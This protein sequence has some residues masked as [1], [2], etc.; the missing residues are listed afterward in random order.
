[1]QLDNNEDVGGLEEEIME[2]GEITSLDFAGVVLEKCRPRLVSFLPFLGQVALNGAFANFDP[3]FEQFP[4]DSFGP[5]QSIFMAICWINLIV[6]GE[7]RGD[8]R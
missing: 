3:Q 7:I 2:D 5:P 8:I 4:S 6:A 1:M